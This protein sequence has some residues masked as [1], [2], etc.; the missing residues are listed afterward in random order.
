MSV[1]INHIV[2]TL[3]VKLDLFNYEEMLMRKKVAGVDIWLFP[4]KKFNLK[5]D[6]HELDIYLLNPVPTDL[7]RLRNA[8][9]TCV[10]EKTPFD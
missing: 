10:D 5:V 6:K 2:N 8:L 7:R 1:L 3:N 9:D 4:E